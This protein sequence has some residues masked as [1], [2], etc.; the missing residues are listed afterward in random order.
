MRNQVQNVT[1]LQSQEEHT[2]DASLRLK[3]SL[4]SA[5]TKGVPLPSANI[6]YPDRQYVPVTGAESSQTYLASR[7]FATNPFGQL[8]EQSQKRDE[9]FWEGLHREIKMA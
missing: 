4:T 5:I 8:A 7:T 1:C 9:T 3:A 2:A 6:L